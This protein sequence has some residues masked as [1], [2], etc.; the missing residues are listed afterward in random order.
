MKKYFWIF[1]LSF[2]SLAL[3]LPSNA[4]ATDSAAITDWYIK[5]FQSDIVVNTDSSLLI[6]EKIT[7]DCGDLPDK[8]GIFRVLPLSYQ[9]TATEIVKTPIKLISIT[10]FNDKPIDYS[11]SKSSL[12]SISTISWKIGDANTTVTGVNYYKI[13]Y[14]VENVVR[15][16]NSAFDEL[17][18]N[19]S[20]NFW[21][22]DIDNFVAIIHL[23]DGITKENS[24]PQLYSGIYS[25]KN[26]TKATNAWINNKN[27]EIKSNSSIE[28]GAGITVSLTFPKNVLTP[29]R[30][31][32][33]IKIFVYLIS[34]MPLL[35]LFLCYKAWK[36]YGRDPKINSA[37]APEFEI[38]E[39]L[40]PISMGLVQTN[41]KIKNE[42][43]SAEIIYLATLG[44]IKIEQIQKKS[45]LQKEDYLLQYLPEHKAKLT[46]E[47]Q[48]LLIKIFGNLKGEQS[49]RLSDMKDTFYT[50]I[51]D[52]ESA[53]YNSLIKAKYLEKIGNNL[54]TAFLATGCVMLF[55]LT[56]ILSSLF[57]TMLDEDI[58]FAL[59]GS[60]FVSAI[61]ILVFSFFMP[62]R[63]DTGAFLEHRIKGFKLYM[64]TAEKYRQQF[65]EKENIFE[66]LLPYA[67]IFGM[68]QK[69]IKTMKSIYGADYFAN[70]HPVWFYGMNGGVFNFDSFAANIESVSSQMA[71]TMA[72]SPSSSGAGG[73]GFS[74]GGGGGGG[75]GG[76]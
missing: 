8:H 12:G 11:T 62:K 33:W 73:G 66:K 21:E 38:P 4:R 74:G 65:N 30:P 9:K 53:V 25:D 58:V 23:P 68:T 50:K 64:E 54:K 59:I 36:K 70:Y 16:D 5:D 51:N 75:G 61:I 1:L 10:D 47:D 22:I 63:T 37:I 71:T 60:S 27:I 13:T 49:I 48:I 46:P 15:F 31:S 40:T 18:W 14:K 7:A 41:G 26:N 32:I 35:V 72:S 2:C 29:Y 45:L 39:K 20:G 42:Y 6:T 19:L 17:Y 43:L 56:P 67:I 34:L 52:V 57:G 76:W 24:T 28:P 3:L 55:I 44:V 69:W